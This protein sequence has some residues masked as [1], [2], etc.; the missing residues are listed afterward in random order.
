MEDHI[1][2]LEERVNKVVR[3]LRALSTERKKLEDELN[4]LREQLEGG[5]QGAAAGNNEARNAWRS[6]KT[7]AIESIR[8]TLAELREA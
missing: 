3:R 6:Q 2:L 1:K 4:L 7:E 5:G 8:Q